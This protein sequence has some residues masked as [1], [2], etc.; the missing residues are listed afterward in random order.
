[1]RES[2]TGK[3]DYPTRVVDG[4]HGFRLR[5]PA[6]DTTPTLPFI[7]ADAVRRALAYPALVDAL[8]NAF[9]APAQVPRRHAHDLCGQGTLLL[10]PAW[11][12]QGQLGVKLVSVMHGNRDRGLP[13]VHALYILLDAQ[14]GVPLALMDGE[15]LTLR[16]TAAVSALASLSLSR[17]DSRTL[18]LVGSGR[19]AP[20]IAVAHCAVREIDRV[21]VW[22][23]DPAKVQQAMRRARAAGLPAQVALHAV[24]SLAQGCE[25][26]DIICCATT[27]TEPLLRAD[28][29]RPGTH[30]DL[31]GGFRPDMREADDALV[32]SARLFVDTAE[33]ALAEAGDLVQPMQAGLLGRDAV[34]AEL[35]QLASGTREGRRNDAEITLFKSVGSALAD[36]ASAGLVWRAW[37]E[38][39]DAQARQG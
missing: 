8:R 25:T 23:R 11:Q 14:T 33:G 34:C 9:A 30:V 21:L 6:M 10:M 19:L 27:S 39:Q 24:A 3:A 5:C 15:Q 18:L 28:W 35:A 7:A 31:V 13:T 32:C 12:P 26:A 22:G 38:S 16:R 17:P 4:R 20:E 36:L 37:C 29:L 1:M 2:V